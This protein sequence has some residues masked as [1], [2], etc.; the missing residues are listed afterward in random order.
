[1]DEEREILPPVYSTDV[2]VCHL[3][4]VHL[5][6]LMKSRIHRVLRDMDPVLEKPILSRIFLGQSA[7]QTTNTM[8]IDLL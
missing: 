8:P 2:F 7:T 3:R 5:T 4:F 6:P 1:M